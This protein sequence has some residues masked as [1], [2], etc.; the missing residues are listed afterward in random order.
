MA[1]AQNQDTSYQPM[2]PQPCTILQQANYWVQPCSQTL[3]SLVSINFKLSSRPI[4]NKSLSA[5]VPLMAVTQ[6]FKKLIRKP[7]Q[8]EQKQSPVSTNVLGMRLL[9]SAQWDEQMSLPSLCRQ[10]QTFV[11]LLAVQLANMQ[12]S[13]SLTVKIKTTKTSET[14]ILACFAK[15]CTNENYQPYSMAIQTADLMV[16]V[17]D[18]SLQWASTLQLRLTAQNSCLTLE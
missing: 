12:F 6:A 9:F 7:E 16:A 10:F 1:S 2:A 4:S 18:S 3:I 13:D 11:Q 8:T 17:L 15:I 5:N 14:R